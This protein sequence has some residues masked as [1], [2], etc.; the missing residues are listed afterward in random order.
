[1]SYYFQ[2][3]N[4][5]L[6]FN[7]FLNN[8]FQLKLF[9]NSRSTHFNEIDILSFYNEIHK[10][11][12]SSIFIKVYFIDF[13]SFQNIFDGQNNIELILTCL[14]FIQKH[15][16]SLQNYQAKLRLFDKIIVHRNIGTRLNCVS[17]NI[18]FLD[19]SEEHTYS[20]NYFFRH[21]SF[22]DLG[23]FEYDRYQSGYVS[24]CF[25]A[26]FRA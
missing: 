13:I 22:L 1:M 19:H 18:N 25:K 23:E 5:N 2:F 26:A 15:H 17:N 16:Q 20:L 8:F 11:L 24:L 4:G 9:T 10:F 7:D 6:V 12:C 3:F 21:N 14:H